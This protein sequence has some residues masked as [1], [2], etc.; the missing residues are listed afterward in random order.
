MPSLLCIENEKSYFQRESFLNKLK[1][2][3]IETITA[4]SRVELK[5]DRF[6]KMNKEENRKKE[7]EQEK[8][9]LREKET[10]REIQS[11]RERNHKKSPNQVAICE[12]LQIVFFLLSN[13]RY[14]AAAKK[15]GC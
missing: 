15:K 10:E 5:N 9:C 3:L 12:L 2:T 8:E 13:F 4:K 6:K 14:I 7:R 11:D 1:M